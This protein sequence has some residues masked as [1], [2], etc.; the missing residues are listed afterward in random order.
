M[1]ESVIFLLFP[2]IF[3]LCWHGGWLVDSDPHFPLTGI[4]KYLTYS[5]TT[6]AVI[7][8]DSMSLLQKV[9]NGM[10]KPDWNVS[11]V[12][13]HLRKLWVYC[14][15]HAG[16]KGN[17]WADRLAGKATLTNGSSWKIWSFEGVVSSFG[18]HVGLV[19]D[20]FDTDCWA[21][22]GST[23]SFFGVF[24]SRP[25]KFI[26]KDKKLSKKTAMFSFHAFFRFIPL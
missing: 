8:T 3:R 19:Y 15:G 11:M 24:F 2:P 18:M 26:K 16:V 1:H 21:Q 6:H 20:I 25:S 10:G 5:R 12:N 23:Q 17:D 7:L 22:N 14:P 4:K 13:I 9:K